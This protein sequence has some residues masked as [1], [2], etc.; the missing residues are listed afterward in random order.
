MLSLAFVQL[1]QILTLTYIQLFV[2][3]ADNETI[4]NGLL[5]IMEE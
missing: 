1:M 2:K 3:R 5:G 4:G